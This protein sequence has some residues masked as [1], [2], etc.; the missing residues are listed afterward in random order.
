ML[1]IG[2]MLGRQKFRAKRLD[3]SVSWYSERKHGAHE[4]LL[5]LIKIL[6]RKNLGSHKYDA[7]DEFLDLVWEYRVWAG[8]YAFSD[9]E[10][11]AVEESKRIPERIEAGNVGDDLKQDLRW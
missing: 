9:F 3:Y 4:I 7:A 8:E 2:R 10:G 1:A 6:E 11:M 5:E